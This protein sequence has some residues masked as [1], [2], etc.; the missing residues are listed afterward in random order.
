MLVGTYLFG[1]VSDRLG[2]R[3]GFQITIAIFAVFC[4]LSAFAQNVEQLAVLRFLTGIGIGGLAPVDT[5]IMTEFMPKHSRG[6]LMAL[7]ALFFP[8]GG[9]VAAFAARLIV[10]E[11]GWRALFLVGVT[12]AFLVLLIRML[13]PESPRFL[14]TIGRTDE[15]R[16]SAEWLGMKPLSAAMATAIV[17]AQPSAQLKSRSQVTL[18]TLFSMD[19]RNRT[20]MLWLLW[21]FWSFSY[22]GLLLWLPSLLAQYHNFE[23][24]DV[25][26]FVIGF[27]TAGIVGRILVASVIDK[28]GRRYSI[29][30]LGLGAA[31]MAVVFGYQTDHTSLYV[32]GFIFAA[33]H[34]GGLSAIAPYT[35]ELYPTQH[36]ATG[37]GY[38]Q[39]WGRVA[40]IL[41]PVT[42]GYLL[43][44]GLMS[45]FIVFGAG[46]LLAAI[47]VFAFNTETSGLVLEEA[48]LEA[49]GSNKHDVETGCKVSED[50]A[51]LRFGG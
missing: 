40:A 10:P 9:V 16:K 34:D 36:R 1:V 51:E 41:S 46:Y 42:V 14:L 23:P 50:V 17:N 37:V 3:F 48:S 35:P 39:A 49:V 12:P 6:K 25:F 33:F 26:T 8:A 21:F 45:V 11:I 43:S 5:A 22:F 44:A 7:W 4:G 28:L 30:L 15:A 18:K 27:M 2:R 19:Y 38:A 29:F 47:V 32:A 13:I 24:T 31:V 20:V